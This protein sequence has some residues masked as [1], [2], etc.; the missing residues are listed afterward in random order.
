MARNE[1]FAQDVFY[2]DPKLYAAIAAVRIPQDHLAST[3]SRIQELEIEVPR[4]QAEDDSWGIQRGNGP[5]SHYVRGLRH[6]LNRL[7]AN[8]PVL[9]DAIDDAQVDLMDILVES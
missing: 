9:E 8:V 6:D 4:L 2:H 5:I 1:Y 7:R 3:L